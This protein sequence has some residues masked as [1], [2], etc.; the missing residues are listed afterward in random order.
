MAHLMSCD[1]G[2]RQ[3]DVAYVTRLFVMPECAEVNIVHK[4]LVPVEEVVAI[5]PPLV[6]S[7]G[8]FMVVCSMLH[9]LQFSFDILVILLSV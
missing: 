9:N 4:V 6:W 1:A 7:F 5:S 8:L 3:N 2:G